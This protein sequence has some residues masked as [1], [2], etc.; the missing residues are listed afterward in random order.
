[1]TDNDYFHIIRD[2]NNYM[3]EIDCE[4]VDFT[5]KTFNIGQREA[6]LRCKEI[7]KTLYIKSK[8]DDD[9]NKKTD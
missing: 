2:I 3:S 1:M 4:E 7:V 5:T 8:G 6:I 9:A